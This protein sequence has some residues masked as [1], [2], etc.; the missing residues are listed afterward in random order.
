MPLGEAL[1]GSRN[2]L[3]QMVGT[4]D[5]LLAALRDPAS[6]GEAALRDAARELH[7]AKEK[8]AAALE[9]VRPRNRRRL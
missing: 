4:L 5:H 6:L 2:A 7:D 8:A 1:R 9:S 3:D